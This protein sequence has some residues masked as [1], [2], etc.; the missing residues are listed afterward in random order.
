CPNGDMFIADTGNHR[1]RRVEG[2]TGTITTVVGV[3]VA[4]SSG[5][6]RPAST[7]PV[8]SPHGLACDAFGNL[9]VTSTTRLRLLPADPSGVVDGTGPVSSIYGEVRD[10]FP[11]SVT[12]CLSGI[13]IID[14]NTLQL[15]DSCAGLL[16]ELHRDVAP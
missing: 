12:T 4:A 1:V 11:A 2:A 3:G 14:A 16:V 6:G 15:T 9:F 7:F 5:D 8:R 10:S 13:A